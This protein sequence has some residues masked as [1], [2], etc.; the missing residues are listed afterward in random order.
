MDMSMK[1]TGSTDALMALERNLGQMEMFT[2]VNLKM[3]CGRVR[4]LTLF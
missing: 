2:R 3:E 1:V 4:E